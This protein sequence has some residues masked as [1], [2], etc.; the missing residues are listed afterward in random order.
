MPNEALEGWRT[1]S[2]GSVIDFING[3]AFKPE[4]WCDAGTPIIRIQ[5]LNGSD[6]FNHFNGDIPERYHVNAGDL[7]FCW[8]GSRGTSFGARKWSGSLG[9]LNQHI[10]RCEVSRDLDDDFAF[11]LLEGMT[12]AIEAEAHGGG[13]LVHI[14]KSEIVKFEASL[15]PLDEQRR[16]AEV[17]RSVDEAIAAAGHVVS[18]LE[19]AASEI[20]ERAFVD[21]D[22]VEPD[23]E[24][25]TFGDL[26]DI[27][28]GNQP[29]KS[30]FVYEPKEGYVRL[31]QIRDFE[32]DDKAAYITETSTKARCEADDILIARYGASVG[33]ILTGKAGAYNV[34][35]TKIVFR[36]G[37]MARRYAYHWLK[38]EYFQDRIRAV[39][40]RSAQAGFNKEDLFPTKI[41]LPTMEAQRDIAEALDD[42]EKAVWANRTQ[43]E[44]LIELKSALLDDLL[45]GRVRVP[46]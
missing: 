24:V 10:F 5:N 44:Q 4:D 8:S 37:R 34:A 20:A 19:S 21:P 30:S 27:K 13:G 1:R 31:L 18:G 14:K 46:A 42:I 38:S 35:L 40:N 28:G 33:R 29:P 41:A 3:F 45:S 17:L 23:C 9:Y 12:G 25:A 39:S 26:F 15:P 2:L 16:I 43:R 36:D 22:A 32:S 7:L 11:Y 6:T